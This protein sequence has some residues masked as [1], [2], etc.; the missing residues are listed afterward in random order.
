MLITL[1]TIGFIMIVCSCFIGGTIV[2]NT[3]KKNIDELNDIIRSL[4]ELLNTIRC[5]K[6]TVF[7][8][9]I[10]ISSHQSIVGKIFQRASQ[11]YETKKNVQ[12]NEILLDILDIYIKKSAIGT[13]ASNSLKYLF[14]RLG[15]NDLE[16]Q[17][18]ILSETVE[19]L[20]SEYKKLSADFEKTKGMYIKASL[21]VGVIVAILFI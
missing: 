7:E 21:C 6:T 2:E 17:I 19:M 12:L 9:M 13:C 15:K 4:E 18:C 3:K 11:E 5:D 20:N 16:Y 1:K 10:G 14:E 8:A